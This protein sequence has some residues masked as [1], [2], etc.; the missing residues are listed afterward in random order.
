MKEEYDSLTFAGHSEKMLCTE[1]KNLDLSLELNYELDT[2]ERI[3]ASLSF[4]LLSE[5]Q[6]HEIQLCRTLLKA[7]RET[8]RAHTSAQ[9]M[10]NTC[11]ILSW[12]I[13]IANK[14]PEYKKKKQRNVE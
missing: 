10:L 4:S 13:I 12:K 6:K 8:Y 2:F 7:M 5:K 9:E 3:S 11:K 14:N 1:P